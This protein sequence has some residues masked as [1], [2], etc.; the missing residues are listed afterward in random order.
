MLGKVLPYA[1]VAGADFVAVLLT[2]R[3]VFGVPIVGSLPLLAL[4]SAGFL[5][6]ALGLGLFVSTVAQSQLQAMLM[7]VFLL[8]PS[9]LLS[10]TIFERALMPVPMQI[11]AYAIPLTYYI[12]ILRGIILRGAGLADLWPSVIPLFA[13]G[14][15]VFAFASIRFARTTR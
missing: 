10:G 6:T 2:M 8:L 4:L 9:V 5:L 7:A 15:V 1:L 14:I 3:F 12:D 11:V 13:Y